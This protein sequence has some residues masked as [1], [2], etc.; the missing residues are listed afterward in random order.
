[1]VYSESEKSW[2]PTGGNGLLE[3]SVEVRRT[4]RGSLIG[5]LFLDAGNVSGASGSPSHYRD[6]FDL[7]ELQLALGVGVRYRTPVGPFRADVA[8]RLPTDWSSDIP[9]SERFPP[10]P[11][12]SGHREPIVVIHVALGEAF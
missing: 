11:G 4:L 5:A 1:M 10:V 8:T 2:V 3:G 6:V 7:S 9:F 12:D